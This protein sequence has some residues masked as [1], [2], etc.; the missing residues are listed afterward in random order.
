MKDVEK[1]IE[2]MYKDVY[3]WGDEQGMSADEKFDIAVYMAGRMRE[4]FKSIKNKTIL[5]LIF[6]LK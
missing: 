1:I 2:K 3:R 5:N 4:Y 6:Q